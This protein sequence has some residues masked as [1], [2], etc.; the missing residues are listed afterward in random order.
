[1]DQKTQQIKQELIEQLISYMDSLD[2]D[3]IKGPQ[4]PEQDEPMSSDIPVEMKKDEPE[5]EGQE[6]KMEIEIK[7]EGEEKEESG[8]DD[9]LLAELEEMYGKIKG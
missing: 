1:M 2:V 7:N 3:R 5:N 9:N 4:Q 8:D 6:P